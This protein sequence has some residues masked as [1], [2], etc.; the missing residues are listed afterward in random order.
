[1][2]KPADPRD[3]LGFVGLQNQGATCYLNSLIQVMYMTPE[4]RDGLY[5]VDPLELGVAHVRCRSTVLRSTLIINSTMHI[6]E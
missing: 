1:M 5:K 3:P 6:H 4:L 2:E